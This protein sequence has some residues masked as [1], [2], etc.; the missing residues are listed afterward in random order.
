MLGVLRRS[1][2][3]TLGELA[4]S[5][6]PRILF[7]YSKTGGGH[8]RSTE[9]IIDAI[10]S[11]F[12]DQFETEMVD[13]LNYYPWPYSKIPALYP[14][15]VEYPRVY[16]KMWY[17]T[18]TP[19]RTK[20]LSNANRT[21]LLLHRA[22][23][24][25]IR[26]HPADLIVLTHWMVVPPMMWYKRRIRAKI[27]TIVTDLVTTH[28][29]WFH[30]RVDFTIV[31]T[32]IAYDNALEN[33]ISADKL[34]Q[35]GLP[36][37][38]KFLNPSGT[39][40]EIR[41]RMGWPLDRP[42]VLFV[43]GGDGMGPLAE[44]VR[45]ISNAKLPITL[46][47]VAGRNRKLK[48]QLESQ[49]WAIPTFIYGFTDE[50]PDFMHAADIFVTKAGPSSVCEALN[51][52][53]PMILYS[54]VVGQEN[55]NVGYVVDTGAGKW[56]PEPRLV[57]NAIQEWL[58]SPESYQAAKEACEKLARPEAAQKIAQFLKQYLLKQ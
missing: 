35:I 33:G 57:V 1:R 42:I 10:H 23:Q 48:E 55:G 24:R 17:S 58:D 18:N 37:T 21:N 4:N 19:L 12:P 34:F 45:A 29:A 5:E 43:G 8:L 49:T 32:Q 26:S 15:L 51:T 6:K 41:T 44:N 56:A 22:H 38:E 52:H 39:S 46:V 30:K 27:G 25:M 7:L 13:F 40:A 31:P 53:T 54:F 47:I 16:G 28:S 14:K 36:V 11:E 50:M 2:V 9:A 20:L 3:K